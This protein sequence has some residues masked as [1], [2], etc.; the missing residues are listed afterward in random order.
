MFTTGFKFW[1][2]ATLIGLAAAFAYAVGSSDTGIV[3]TVLG[4]V[5]VGYKGAVGEHSGYTILLGFAGISLL[6][7]LIMAGVRDADP[8]SLAEVA[9]VEEVPRPRPPAGPSWWPI[10][11]AIG[12][13]LGAVGAVTG[14]SFSV[15]GVA[16]VTVAAVEWTITAWADRVTIDPR[17]NR[18][19]RS[20]LMLPVEIP[21]IGVLA[22]GVVVVSG[23]RILLAVSEAGSVAVAA[24]LASVVFV[25]AVAFASRS[26]P[27]RSLVNGA[28]L[29]G[30]VALLAGGVIAATSG[31]RDFHHGGGGSGEEAE[32][33][34][35]G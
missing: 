19:L 2:A 24:A 1:F 8:Q 30:A 12:A 25:L 13:A 35:N 31:E 7:A 15:I 27:P 6:M 18:E 20:R 22:I 29:I 10:I 32:T 28:L 5:S 23:S 3:D 14:L 33:P 26:N 9:R 34:G 17:A 21:V 11:G 4:P 16:L